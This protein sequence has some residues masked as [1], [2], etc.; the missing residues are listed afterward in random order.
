LGLPASDENAI[1]DIQAILTALDPA[2]E[3]KSLFGQGQ[4]GVLVINNET[5]Q[6][7]NNAGGLNQDILQ[8]LFDL[9]FN[10]IAVATDDLDNAV[11]DIVAQDPMPPVEVTVIGIDVNSE[12][13]MQHEP[14][15]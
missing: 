13:M 10:E 9:G 4:F 5:A 12:L 2:N 15:K 7:I 3:A 14:M 8:D 1:A 6:A 11:T